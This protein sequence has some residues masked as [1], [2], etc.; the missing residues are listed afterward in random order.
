MLVAGVGKI[1]Y[2]YPL[3]NLNKKYDVKKI[4]NLIN[5][6]GCRR[7]FLIFKQFFDDGKII[8]LKDESS[9]STAK[10]NGR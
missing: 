3:G 2:L 5:V 1:G 6:I 4:N 8:I 7:Y 10:D 9:F